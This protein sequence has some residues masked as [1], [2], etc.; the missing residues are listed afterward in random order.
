MDGQRAVPEAV[1]G[2]V[3]LSGGQT[4]EVATEN[5]QAINALGSQPWELSYSYARALQAPALEIWKGEDC[6]IRD[7]QEAFLR[8]AKLVSAARGGKVLQS[9]RSQHRLVLQ[10]RF[11]GKA[12]GCF[13]S[14]DWWCNCREIVTVRARS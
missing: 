14:H 5:L 11:R 3:F 9:T 8:R 1:P 6:N 12:S 7:A 13:A 10:H 2:I 4:P